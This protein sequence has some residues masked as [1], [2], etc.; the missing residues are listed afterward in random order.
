MSVTEKIGMFFFTAASGCLLL[1]CFAGCNSKKPKL[2]TLVD[3]ASTNIDFENKLVISDSLNIMN[4]IYLYNGGG[5]SI[6]DINNDGLEDI[7][8]SSNTGDNKLYLN[9]GNMK[10]E[11]I[12]SKAGLKGKGNWKT[13]IT[14][15][16]VNGDGLLDIYVCAVEGINSFKGENQLYINNGNLT[17]SDKAATYGLNEKGL[18]TQAVFFDYDLDGD[19][20]MYL[21]RHSVPTLTDYLDTVYRHI[22]DSLS[23]D[24]LFRNE[25]DK[26][27]EKFT[28]VT[29]EA[30][31]FSGKTGYGL[32]AIVNDFNRDGWPDIYVSN[33]FYEEDY[34]YINNK[35]GTFTE[36]NKESFGHESRFSMGSDAAD[37]NND[38]WPDLITLDMLP[39]DEKILKSSVS[40]DPL[41]IYNFKNK[42]GY[43]YQFSKNCLQLNTGHGKAFQDIGLYAGVAATDWSWS[44]LLADFNNDGYCDLFVSNGILKRPNDLDFIKY[45]ANA[46]D[47]YDINSHKLSQ[48]AYDLMPSGEIPNYLF[49]GTA[50]L[51]FTNLSME[52]GFEKPTLSTGAAYADL[53][54]DGDLDIVVNNINGVAGVYQNNSQNNK[55]NYLKIK[56]KSNSLNTE[57]IGASVI[58][59]ANDKRYYQYVTPAKGFESSSSVKLNF[60]LG[61]S[62]KI[63]SVEVIW[64]DSKITR[65]VYKNIKCNQ[66]LEIR[67]SS[68]NS[69]KYIFG[70]TEPL[71]KR[72]IAADFFNYNHNE[73]DFDDYDTQQLIPHGISTQ[74]PK[75]ALADVNNDGME[76]MFIC[77]ASGRAGEL[78][79]QGKTGAF[80]KSD[81]T[82]FQQ[83][84]LCED[85]NAVF[86]DADNDGDNDLYVVSG[87]NEVEGYDPRLFD[88]LYINDGKGHFS[89]SFSIP[90]LGGNKSVAVAADIDKDGDMDLFIGG[91][92]VAG[93]YGLTPKSFIL[94]N[95]GKGKFSVQTKIVC[96][97]LENIGM[98]T[99]AKW[100]DLNNDGWEDLVVVGEWMP[101]SIF[102]NENGKLVNRTVSFGLDKTNGLWNTLAVID[103]NNDHKPDI[104][105]GNLGEN[106]KLKATIEYPLMMYYAD[107][108]KTGI[109]KQIL[110]VNKNGNYYTFLGKEELER[111]MPGFIRKKYLE[112]RTF[113]GQTTSQ[114]FGDNFSPITTSKAYTLSTSAWINSGTIFKQMPLPK[115]IQWA[116]VFSIKVYDF[117]NDGN[118]DILTGGNM[119]NVLPYEGRYD[120]SYGMVML[121]TGNGKFKNMPVEETGLLIKGEV[122]DIKIIRK[123]NGERMLVFAINNSAAACYRF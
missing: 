108:D 70:N 12:T 53:D 69:S 49:T 28:D 23:G 80:K 57:A 56:L 17:F 18:N 44:P 47:A 109:G 64:P 3:S 13:G 24:K 105:A 73:N 96:K 42:I 97:E 91:R 50:S 25:M 112:Y 72:M 52:E 36:K 122:R 54:N 94:I 48:K 41:D 51:Q 119:Y 58:V 4:Y 75:I 77:G 67:Q 107:A 92:A 98:V 123:N 34:Y 39:E 81:E 40:D 118:M 89:K 15:A 9:K 21:V 74:G 114:V 88:R 62:T 115:E 106:S 63:D 71:F 14:M 110:S 104:I 76:D 95:D 100:V 43:H 11:D 33:D 30:G 101:I 102:L 27:I 66:L 7:Y 78:W 84:K 10:F 116:P 65:Q 26:G 16:D 86:F 32:N 35:N 20:D 37:I 6:G 79:L 29:N 59:S 1:V 5:V 87:G 2:F 90:N 61:N 93:Q 46:A 31:I 103:I 19:L 121:G 120:A 55:E 38:G 60:G 117:N 82:I 45:Y 83:D 99:D 85:V 68:E 111:V 22:P 113:A 8:F